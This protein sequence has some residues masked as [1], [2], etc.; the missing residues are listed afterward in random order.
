MPSSNRF[1]LSGRGSEALAN[2]EVL[3]FRYCLGEAFVLG[4]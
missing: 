4:K 3:E 1:V 2:C